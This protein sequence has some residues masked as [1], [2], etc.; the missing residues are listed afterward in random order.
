[1]SLP[2]IGASEVAVILGHGRRRFDGTLYTSELELWS[3]LMGLLPRYDTDT[4]AAAERGHMLEWGLLH[5]Y[6]VEQGLLGV[7]GPALNQPPVVRSDIPFLHAR[8][9]AA[10]MDMVDNPD[11]RLAPSAMVKR[12]GE[13]KTRKWLDADEGWGEPGTDQVPLDVAVQVQVQLLVVGCVEKVSAVVAYGTV[14]DDYR[15]YLLEAR[16]RVQRWIV[17]RVDAW[18][19]RYVVACVPPD[20][21]GSESARRTLAHVHRVKERREVAATQGDLERVHRLMAIREAQA[22]LKVQAELL[23]QQ[24]KARLGKAT[25]LV[26]GTGRTVVSWRP[27]SSSLI[28]VKRLRKER[29][30]IAKQYPLD[31]SSRR[32]LVHNKKEFSDE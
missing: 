32:F 6:A 1:M 10:F 19:Q 30:D 7:P 25:D 31:G 11:D 5:R 22:E 14:D 28:D 27:T 3:R 24:L 26:D 16:P 12:L 2:T 13:A 29:P 21:D 20:P 18:V 23:E 17:E 4:S 8:H 15:V 9:D